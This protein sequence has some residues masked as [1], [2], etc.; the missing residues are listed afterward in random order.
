MLRLVKPGTRRHAAVYRLIIGEQLIE[1]VE[2]WTPSRYVLEIERT[3]DKYRGRTRNADPSGVGDQDGNADSTGVSE[4]DETPTPQESALAADDHQIAD[5]TGTPNPETPTPQ[6][7]Q[8]P[9]PTESATNHGPRGNYDQ[10]ENGDHRTDVA[11]PRARDDPTE[12]TFASLRRQYPKLGPE[13]CPKHPGLAAGVRPDD[14]KPRCPICRAL[15]E[16]QAA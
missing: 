9:T 5:S 3:S 8:T 12:T 11:G 13:H 10:P 2:L 15:P 7:P 4:D 16:E 1:N 6:G 14:G